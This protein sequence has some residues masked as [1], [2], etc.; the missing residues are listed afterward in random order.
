MLSIELGAEE[1]L[2]HCQVMQRLAKV[3][4]T[5]LRC[6]L[7]AVLVLHF[8]SSLLWYSVFWW[9]PFDASITGVWLC[10][11]SVWLCSCTSVL[12]DAFDASITGVWLCCSASS[13]LR[14]QQQ[15]HAR[16]SEVTQQ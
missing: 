1:V 11:T 13:A 2:L 16:S 5:Q 8:A 12:V 10:F 6:S 15:D 4:L 7:S 3:T 9:L 14:C